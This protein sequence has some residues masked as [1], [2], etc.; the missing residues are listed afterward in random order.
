MKPDMSEL[1]AAYR[2]AAARDKRGTVREV[3]YPV[4]HYI[5]ANRQL[6]TNRHIDRREAGRETVR[7]EA[8]LKSCNVYLP[9]GY[10]ESDPDTR[11]PALYLLHGVGGDQYE[12]L[13]GSGMEMDSPRAAIANPILWADVP[14]PCVIRSGDIWQRLV[15]RM[16]ATP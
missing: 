12:W 10:D 7:G 5:N 15:G 2:R 4:N 16:L 1:P 9:A 6:V 3:S 13:R 8:I 14:D 11:Y